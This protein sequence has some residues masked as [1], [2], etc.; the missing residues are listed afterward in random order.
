[1]QTLNATNWVKSFIDVN[2]LRSVEEQFGIGFHQILPLGAFPHGWLIFDDAFHSSLQ[3]FG[4]RV[5]VSQNQSLHNIFDFLTAAQTLFTF[6]LQCLDLIFFSGQ[7]QRL[8]HFWLF[9]IRGWSSA[10]EFQHF[11][12]HRHAN[13]AQL[14]GLCLPFFK[15]A[16]KHGGQY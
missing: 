1:M 9:H 6:D 5:Q 10:N 4:R 16:L 15:F 11:F 7:E 13:V 2:T 14:Y 12:Q 8:R 3:Q